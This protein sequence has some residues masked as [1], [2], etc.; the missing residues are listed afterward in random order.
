MVRWQ[1][2]FARQQ[3]SGLRQGLSELVIWIWVIASVVL[4][5][6]LG[7]AVF[8]ANRITA[9]LRK[10]R[11][12]A[13]QLIRDQFH[14]PTEKSIEVES[15]ADQLTVNMDEVQNIDRSFSNNGVRHPRTY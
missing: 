12:A 4:L 11:V 13:Q 3:E 2:D 6:V 8:F 15:K 7:L 9:P 1:T 14:K 10:L 5:L